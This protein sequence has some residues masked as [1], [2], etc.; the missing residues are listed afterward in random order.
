[1][2][3]RSRPRSAAFPGLLL[4]LLGVLA[5]AAALHYGCRNSQASSQEQASLASAP[6]PRSGGGKSGSGHRH[7]H[8]RTAADGSVATASLGAPPATG[9]PGP[10]GGE[11]APGAVVHPHPRVAVVV[12]DRGRSVEEVEAL[13]KLGVPLTYAVLPY[14]VETP[15]VVADLHR[16]GVEILCHLP[17]EPTGS[18]DP[19]P[20]ALRF[21]M[22]GEQ[23]RQATAA[24]LAA[25]PGA[26]GVNNHMGSRLS[27]DGTSMKIIL[28]VLAGRGLFFLDSRTSP[29]SVG[30]RLAVDLKVPTAERQVFLD[31]DQRAE[32]IHQQFQRLLNLAR[33]NGEAIAIGH[34]HPAT[35]ATLSAEVPAAR[36]QGFEF[37]PVSALLRR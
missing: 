2:P 27:A 32:M 6:V 33:Q 35:L 7:T 13:A 34:P 12:D 10:T 24:A 23:L 17:M 15:Q 4:F 26:V 3:R 16:R 18:N 28:G 1:M 31:G 21:G 37:V 20:G 8:G 25:V 29:E 19:G 9:Q 36:E 22:D 11:V 14:E 30:Y 5:G